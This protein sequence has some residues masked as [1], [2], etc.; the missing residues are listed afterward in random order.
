MGVE[1]GRGCRRR[2]SDRSGRRV[3]A[4]WGWREGVRAGWRGGKERMGWG[5][6]GGWRWRVKFDE[7]GV[8]RRRG[9]VDV[10]DLRSGVGWGNR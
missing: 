5:L 3:G 1:G 9:G 6:R 7:E 2:G 10:E 8:L 4:E